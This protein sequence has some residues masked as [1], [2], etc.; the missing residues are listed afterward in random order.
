MVHANGNYCKPNYLIITSKW[1]ELKSK[2]IY[3]I[4][5]LNDY[6]R[7]SNNDLELYKQLSDSSYRSINGQRQSSRNHRE[8]IRNT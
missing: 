2:Y 1:R 5:S 6:I 8:I 4:M 7:L 3:I